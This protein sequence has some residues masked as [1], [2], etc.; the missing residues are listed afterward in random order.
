MLKLPGTAESFLARYW[1]KEYL[2][3]PGALPG[4]RPSISRNE[5]GWLATLEDDRRGI[6][7]GRQMG[8]HGLS[9]HLANLVK[10]TVSQDA[11]ACLPDL[12]LS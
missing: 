4:V 6:D 10:R 5:L 1:Q 12:R 8:L 7:V 3:M 2:F 11:H 9:R